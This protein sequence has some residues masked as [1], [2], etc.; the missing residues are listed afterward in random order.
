MRFF[1]L[2][3]LVFTFTSLLRK[4]WFFSIFGW[5]VKPAVQRGRRKGQ[6]LLRSASGPN[7]WVS[8]GKVNVFWILVQVEIVWYLLGSIKYWVFKF[9]IRYLFFFFLDAWGISE[10]LG[11]NITYDIVTQ[12]L[13]PVNMAL[14]PTP[15]KLMIS[16]AHG[17]WRLFNLQAY[18]VLELFNN[19]LVRGFIVKFHL[20]YFFEYLLQRLGANFDKFNGVFV[21][22]SLLQVLIELS[23]FVLKLF[24]EIAPRQLIFL[25]EV[26]HNVE[27]GLNVI[28]SWWGRFVNCI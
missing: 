22:Q 14:V 23:K 19:F 5:V 20:E 8:E 24:F 10:N 13:K 21:G 15:L 26:D 2:Q 28:P 7:T 18:H 4:L 12:Y 25:E 11:L 27:C 1:Q 3:R 6:I 16:I 17:V 9:L